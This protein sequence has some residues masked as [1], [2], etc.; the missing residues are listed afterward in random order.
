MFDGI[1]KNIRFEDFIRN[2]KQLRMNAPDTELIFTV[3]LMRQNLHQCEDMVRLVAELGINKVIFSK[4]D[5][6]YVIGNYEDSVDLYP[7]TLHTCLQRA[8][9]L[10]KELGV[11]V[12]VQC[13]LQELHLPVDC[14]CLEQKQATLREMSF[15]KY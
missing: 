10:G 5:I 11:D 7:T 15:W 9:T 4:V 14:T 12:V 1:R 3:V 6:N 8:A 2:V 13:S